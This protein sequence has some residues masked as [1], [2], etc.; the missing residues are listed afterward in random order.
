[1]NRQFAPWPCGQRANRI[2]TTPLLRGLSMLLQ[3]FK[4]ASECWCEA[5]ARWQR[6]V[7]DL[8]GPEAA[9]RGWYLR[10][11]DAQIG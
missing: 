8:S 9:V 6:V 4:S 1:M 2:A 7:G 10:F 11:S 3:P 5:H